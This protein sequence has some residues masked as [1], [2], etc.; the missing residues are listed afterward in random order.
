[1][2]KE[3]RVYDEPVELRKLD[4]GEEVIE[5]YAVVFNSESRDLGGFVETIAPTASR[6]ADISD[7]LALFNHDQNLILGRT[8]TTLSLS[9]DEH[10][11]RYSIKPPD[12][13]TANDLKKSIARGDVRGS[14]FGF[15]IAKDGDTWEKPKEK[16]GLYR[17]LVTRITKLWDVSPVATPAYVTT[18]TTIAKRELGMLKDKE[19]VEVTQK[20]Q[21]VDEIERLKIRRQI[22]SIEG[23]LAYHNNFSK[24]E[25]AE[26]DLKS[27]KD[28]LRKQFDLL[29][30]KQ[31]KEQMAE[32]DRLLTENK[33]E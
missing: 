32:I 8:P 27:K 28:E 14:S 18:D 23:T 30:N 22:L 21:E 13:T 3:L 6:D 15:S 7:V 5:G 12:T 25:K 20:I 9:I 17:R 24:L 31:K 4:T 1:M 29:E 33:E 19:E 26:A 11:V 16:G 2:E 10:G